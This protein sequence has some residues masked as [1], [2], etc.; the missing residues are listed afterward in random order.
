MKPSEQIPRYSLKDYQHWKDDWELIY[1]Y[2]YAMSPSPF[3]KHQLVSHAFLDAFRSGLKNNSNNCNCKVLSE[4]DW[5]IDEQ[6]VVRPD[7]MIVCGDIKLDDH[8]RI[9]PVLIVEVSSD[10]TRLK[11][12]NIKFKLYEQCGVKY[13]IMADP[14]RRSIE[15]FQLVNNQ[16]QETTAIDEFHL[17]D[18]CQVAF[19]FA[20]VFEE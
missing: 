15:A 5:I 10:K 2:P 11:D 7:V 1:G 13:Y 17:N 3:I 6:T 14:E 19:H 16:Y 20:E 8:L 12:R 18:T 9:P 4:T